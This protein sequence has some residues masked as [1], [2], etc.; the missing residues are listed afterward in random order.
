MKKMKRQNKR[1][2]K[3]LRLGA[4]LEKTKQLLDNFYGKFDNELRNILGHN[5]SW[6]EGSVRSSNKT[7]GRHTLS[8]SSRNETMSDYYA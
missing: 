5:F 8:S 4:M 3:D 7:A 1:K 6:E 2:Y